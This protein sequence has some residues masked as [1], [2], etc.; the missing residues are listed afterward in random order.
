MSINLLVWVGFFAAGIR[1]A[2]SIGFAA[3]GETISERAGILNVGIEGIMLVGAFLAV[4]GAVTTGS[5]WGG[6]ALA[7]MGG[8][9]L[10]ALHGFFVISLR[11]DQVVSGVGI[12][13]LGLGLSS[14]L[15][16][17]TLGKAQYSVP[18][19][20]NVDL[21]P[22]SKLSFVG[23]VF[24]SQNIL[25]YVALAATLVLAW[26]L[27]RSALG[28][29]WRACGEN[30]DAL[31]AA[32]VSVVARRYQAVILGGAFA[33]LGGAYLAIA[34]INVFVEN[35]VVGR[36]FIAIACVVFGRWRPV[37]VTVAAVGFGLAE[38]AQIRLQTAYPDVPYQLFVALPYVLAI[39]ALVGLAR[40]A[41]NSRAL[42]QSYAGGR[43]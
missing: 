13:I 41:A 17:L 31:A 14:F 32:G 22:L 25:V 8:A 35:M 43:G 3:L 5:P 37:G 6:V 33:G 21:G 18:A 12:V 20:H 36:G 42:G 28:L 16:R 27:R 2:V 4:F 10:G 24:F 40:G 15:F 30:P 26:L 23:P 39:V 34:Q 29:E 7:L 11:T 9:M 19:F 38:A 1:L